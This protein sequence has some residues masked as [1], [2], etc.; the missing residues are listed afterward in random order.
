MNW[1]EVKKENINSILYLIFNISLF[2]GKNVNTIR[3]LDKYS[4]SLFEID[5][6]KMKIESFCKTGANILSSVVS[7]HVC[8]S[9]C[10]LLQ[11]AFKT[12]SKI[13]KIH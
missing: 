12:I 8:S 9:A 2:S 11:Y 6:T 5:K 7:V 1:N 4:F 3:I 10:S 13:H